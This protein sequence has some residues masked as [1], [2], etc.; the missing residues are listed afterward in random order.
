MSRTV[1]TYP[2]AGA[3]VAADEFLGPNRTWNPTNETQDRFLR[4]FFIPCRDELP[5][6]P[7]LESMASRDHN[8]LN[9]FLA[10]HGFNGSFEPF[11][12]NKFGTASVLDVLVKWLMPGEETTLRTPEGKEYP[13]VLIEE[14]NPSSRFH[15]APDE[16]SSNPIIELKTGSGDR[17]FLYQ[18]N[19]DLDGLNLV[20]YAMELTQGLTPSYANY[21]DLTFPMVDLKDKPDIGWLMGMSTVDEV[22]T[23]WVVEGAKQQTIFKMNQ[24]GARAKS[25]VE[26]VFAATAFVPRINVVIDQPFM[27][28]IVRDG[29]N[30]PFF[31][32][33]ITEEDW[34][35]PGDLE[36]NS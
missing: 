34:M 26:M 13:A 24:F 9:Q 23:P 16:D 6:I 17:V 12:P 33:Y 22:N 31:T 25:A 14:H 32:G 1:V 5:R 30:V 15:N 21:A 19:T 3:V 8:A 11:D 10:K 18:V 2:I 27:V 7:E 29:L 20:H 35:N 36:D 28:W 4:S